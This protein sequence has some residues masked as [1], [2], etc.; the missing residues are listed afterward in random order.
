MSH[1]E[2]KSKKS[3]LKFLY[4]ISANNV[5]QLFCF[6][7]TVSC[8]IKFAHVCACWH[9]CNVCVKRLPNVPA[10][11]CFSACNFARFRVKKAQFWPILVIKT[12]FYTL[13]WSLIPNRHGLQTPGEEIIFTAQPKIKSNPNPKFLGTAKS[14]FVCHT[15]LIFQIS[16]IYAFIGCP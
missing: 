12:T 16:L 5:Q 3:R 6:E 1:I 7:E 2:P 11:G 8:K 9:V 13:P 15:G 4:C 14:Y 10:C